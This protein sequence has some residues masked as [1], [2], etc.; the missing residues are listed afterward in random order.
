MFGDLP[1]ITAAL[2]PLEHSGLYRIFL[3]STRV[4]PLPKGT[5]GRDALASTGGTDIACVLNHLLELPL[6]VF[7]PS[8]PQTGPR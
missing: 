1:W 4:A 6:R 5:I 2:R 3:F 8:R 7:Q